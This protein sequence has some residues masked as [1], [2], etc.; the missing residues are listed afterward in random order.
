MPSIWNVKSFNSWYSPFVCL[1]K[2]FSLR[3]HTHT[4]TKR[5]INK[6]NIIFIYIYTIYDPI[7]SLVVYP[8]PF[9]RALELSLCRFQAAAIIYSI[10]YILPLALDARA[11]RCW[12][13][14]NEKLRHW[15]K[16][17]SLY[18]FIYL[19]IPRTSTQ[20]LEDNMAFQARVIYSLQ[21]I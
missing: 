18:L 17:R 21:L 4:R 7:R 14:T 12:C 5:I 19:L 10:F 9:S 13:W 3:A 15:W 1:Y 20:K 8:S 11:R 16:K 6:A 2:D